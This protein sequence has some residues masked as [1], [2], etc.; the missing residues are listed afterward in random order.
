MTE[1]VT[2]QVLAEHWD[3]PFERS[4]QDAAIAALEEG[5]V[6]V[7][8]RLAFALAPAEAG[9]LSAGALDETRKNISADPATGVVHGTALAGAE[10]AALTAMMTRFRGQAETLVRQLLPG[11]AGA[12]STA[13]TSFRPAEIAGRETAPRK[14]DKRLHVDA[15]PTRPMRGRRILRVFSNI[16]M[17]G[18]KRVWRVGEPF[19]AFAQKFLPRVRP[20]FAGQ[21]ALMERLGLTKGRRAP[22]DFLMLGLHDAAKLDNDYQSGAP[23]AELTFP[24]G[25]TWMCFTDAVLHAAMAGRCALEQT[26]HIPVEAMASPERA[27]L[28]V[29]E[30]LTGRVLA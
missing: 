1:Q 12:L 21:A 15:F 18:T 13:R 2:L 6:I 14:D 20:G 19:P 25:T 29:L 23:A 9:L 27:P 30:S 4:A 3:A 10:L 8:P 5:R 28:R 17:D 16:A 7:L 24:P 26:F 11:Y 22:Y